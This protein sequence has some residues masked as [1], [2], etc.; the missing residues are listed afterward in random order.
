MNKIRI[1]IIGYGN[2]GKGVV[3]ALKFNPDMELKVDFT[4]SNPTFSIEQLVAAL[5]Q[6]FRP[7]PYQLRSEFQC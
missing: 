1:G 2:L 3:K 6:D 4:S 7:R 5:Q